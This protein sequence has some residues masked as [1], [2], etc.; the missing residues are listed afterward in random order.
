MN[1]RVLIVDDS[2][3]MRY[4]LK[5]IIES[6]GG[7]VIGEAADGVEAVEKF[8]ELQ[9]N[10]TFLDITMPIMNGI[11]ALK[12]IKDQNQNA[13]VIMVTAMSQGS[14]IRE[15]LEMGAADYICKPF[16]ENNI[17]EIMEKY[18]IKSDMESGA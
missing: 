13:K 4:R 1:N 8:R 10:L 5:S 6:S 14:F 3:F 16:K 12:K 7:I 9:P 18:L 15:S 17:R 2:L 11:C